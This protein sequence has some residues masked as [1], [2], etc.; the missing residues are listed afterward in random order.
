MWSL[1]ISCMYKVQFYFNVVLVS[2]FVMFVKTYLYPTL[3]VINQKFQ[4]F[5]AN[6]NDDLEH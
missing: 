2:D 6:F 1:V 4:H 5:L 3:G